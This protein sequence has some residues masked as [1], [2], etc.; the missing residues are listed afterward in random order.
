MTQPLTD[1]EYVIKIALDAYPNKILFNEEEFK[2]E[3][4]RFYITR[5]MA[6]RFILSGLVSDKLLLNNVIICLNVFGIVA[7]NLIWKVICRDD[8]FGVIKSCLMFLN[9]LNTVDPVPHHKKMLDI[10]KEIRHQYTIYS[11]N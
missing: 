7:S 11:N 9:S 8:E 2:R 10:L 3:F 5:K 4:F 1:R 6:R